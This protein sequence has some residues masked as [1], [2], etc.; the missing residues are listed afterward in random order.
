[1]VTIKESPLST[2]VEP[3]PTMVTTMSKGITREFSL[4]IDCETTGVNMD[5]DQILQIAVVV[6]DK[7]F[8]EIESFTAVIQQPQ[9]VLDSCSDWARTSHSSPKTELKMSLFEQCL[10]PCFSMSLENAEKAIC[11]IA[12]RYRDGKYIQVGGSSVY[13]DVMFMRR[14]MPLLFSKIHF[15]LLDVSTYLEVTIRHSK[16]ILKEQPQ[17][18]ANHDALMDARSSLQ[19]MYFY[20]HKYHRKPVVSTKENAGV[21][22]TLSTSPPI[23]YSKEQSLPTK[24]HTTKPY[25]IKWP[26][27]DLLQKQKLNHKTTHQ[28]KVYPIDNEKVRPFCVISQ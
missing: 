3:N 1:M 26:I 12:D 13:V 20:V 7:N 5:S 2:K 23:S 24:N 27:K 11:D 9:S 22:K 28:R 14:W 6:A 21:N 25:Q 18:T 19:L 17:N 16:D 10:D 4:W 8:D 15:R